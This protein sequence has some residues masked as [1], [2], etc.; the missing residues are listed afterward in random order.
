MT[1]YPR[2]LNVS[3]RAVAD[4]LEQKKLQ[5]LEVLVGETF[6]TGIR[7]SQK[8]CPVEFRGTFVCLISWDSARSSVKQLKGCI[9]VTVSY[10]LP[11]EVGRACQILPSRKTKTAYLK[12]TLQL[13]LVLLKDSVF[14]QR[15]K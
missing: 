2:W 4:V 13:N 15:G 5:L 8:S 12:D 9:Y 7:L 11:H 10:S 14:L 3:E 1:E 6:A